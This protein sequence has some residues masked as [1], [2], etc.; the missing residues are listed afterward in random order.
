M[1]K[2]SPIYKKNN[3]NLIEKRTSEKKQGLS[4]LEI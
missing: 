3:A 1:L 4:T 2:S